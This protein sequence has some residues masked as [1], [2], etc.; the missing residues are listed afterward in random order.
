MAKIN[1]I[2]DIDQFL[3][4]LS[5]VICDSYLLKN[6]DPL[7]TRIIL[8]IHNHETITISG[9]PD[10]DGATSLVE[11]YKYLKNFTDDVHYVCN[12]RSEG[13]SINNLID[14]IP[15]RT[16]LFIAV[17]SSSNDTESMKALV[18]K[19]I[20]CLI[21]DHHTITND[22]PYAII[23]N[24][25]Q[26][27]CKYPNKNACGGLLV[28]KVCEVIDDYMNTHYAHQLSD[29][30]GFSLMADMMSMMELENRYF[31]KLSL[32]GLRHAGLKALFSA[33]NFDLSNLSATDFLYGVSPA[34]T[35]ATR[36]D[37]I[38][39]AIDFLMCDEESPE[40]KTI[41]KELIKLNENRKVVQA[42]ALVRLKP[43]VN[44]NDKVVIVIDHTLG[45]GMNGLVAQELCRTYSRPAIV[46]GN[47]DSE[48]TYA[49]SFRGLEDFS[50]LDMLGDCNNVIHTGG[51][52]GAGGLQLLKKDIEVL[53]QELNEKLQDFVADNSLYYDLE[54]DINQINENL[55]NYLSEF[56]RITG[57]KFKQ[58]RFLIKGL[59]VSDKKLMGQSNNTVKID[60]DK[61]QLMKFKTDVNYYKS[62]PVFSEI[63]AIGTLNI[64]VWKVYRPK[65]KVTKTLQLFIEDY[66][67]N[68]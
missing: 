42:E 61:L 13:H 27:G 53:R 46:L 20:D 26:E 17:D 10:F 31:A 54:F 12:E 45:K 18:D 14:Q 21:I 23:V 6:I 24:P 55:I 2:E 22:N 58:G 8:A 49:G 32:K 52:D 38:Q 3:N 51:H 62:V 30:P 9:D 68:K 16:K 28:F 57:N 56:Y 40:I 5:N 25:Q 64:N 35:A 15:K 29:L 43:L 60:C 37:N 67:E 41:V 11:L 50:M 33:M 19:G 36:A 65:F 44:V 39:L 59:F 63:E 4:P 34:V 47:G 1:G 66:R 48:D 7:V